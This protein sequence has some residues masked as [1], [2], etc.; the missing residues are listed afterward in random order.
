V[1]AVAGMPLTPAGGGPLVAT[2]VDEGELID[3]EF[4]PP[5]SGMIPTPRIPLPPNAASGL[6]A[7][8]AS[9]S[10]HRDTPP[11]VTASASRVEKPMLHARSG[12]GSTSVV[13]EIRAQR[14]QRARAIVVAV[15]AAC[16]VIGG[17]AGWHA[18]QTH[19]EAPAAIVAETAHP[20]SV[21]KPAPAVTATHAEPAPLPS[22]PA[23][24]E[25][26]EAEPAVIDPA[27]EEAPAVAAPAKPTATPD[28]VRSPDTSAENSA[29]ARATKAAASPAIPAPAGV[30][31]PAA[32]PAP[33]AARR[34]KVRATDSPASPPPSTK[35]KFDPTK[36]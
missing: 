28:Q 23:V 7:S 17:A 18:W 25:P 1:I 29:P 36:I 12:S 11:A 14:A 26:A 22:E 8:V 2:A 33:P 21:Q 3:L 20:M 30:P 10:F 16:A 19:Q 35:P 15:G 34:P 13:E 4:D 6:M 5:S 27:A 31:S 32:A 9:E 24:V